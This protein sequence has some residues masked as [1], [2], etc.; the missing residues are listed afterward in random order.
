MTEEEY[1]ELI[2]SHW[3]SRN[4]LEPTPETIALCDKSVT[5][6]PNSARLWVMRGDLIQLMNFEDDLHPLSE[7]EH[8]YRMAITA[9]PT[10]AEAYTELGIFLDLMSKPRKAKQ[11]FRKAWLIGRNQSTKTPP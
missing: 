10:D 2:K 7:I 8:S 9:D 4:E 1:F 6:F 5:E 11:Y 3:P